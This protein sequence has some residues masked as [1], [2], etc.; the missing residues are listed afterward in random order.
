[1]PTVT[2][3][4]ATYQRV[5]AL[6]ATLR[7]LIL[8]QHADWT[9]LVIG[10]HCEEETAHVIRELHEPRIRYYNLPRR[11][12]E[13][14][15]P[16]S[17][18]L[19]IAGGDYI[20]FLNHDDLLLQDHLSYA[21]ERIRA[22]DG[23]FFMGS[24]ANATELKS[25]NSGQTVPVF[26]E[27]LPETWNLDML[28]QDDPYIFDPSSFWLIRTPYAQS[29]GYWRPARHLWRTPLRDWLMRAWRMGGRFVSGERVTGLR[30]WTQNLRKGNPL[31]HNTTPEHVFMIDYMQ[32]HS[33]DEVRAFIGWAQGNRQEK[34]Y[35][36]EWSAGQVR[37]ASVLYRKFGVDAYLLWCRMHRR[38]RGALLKRITQKRTGEDL[39][40]AWNLQAVWA[41]PEAHRVL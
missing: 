14:S 8:Q 39:H 6:R 20:G 1:M 28:V 10:D 2:Y 29:V 9:A 16:N 24:Y 31:Y 30:F 17:F 7:S 27:A 18:G 22:E 35:V 32:Q 26:P 19:H 3:I 11:F 5:E 13:Q 38:P 23:D 12:G 15:G 41:D 33:A 21:L 36:P 4:I 34:P 25:D 40:A 37:A